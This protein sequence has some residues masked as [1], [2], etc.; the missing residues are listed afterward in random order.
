MYVYKLYAEFSGPYSGD[1][2]PEIAEGARDER[3]YLSSED[4]PE[5]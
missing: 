5:V 1:I 3:K 4:E 2:F